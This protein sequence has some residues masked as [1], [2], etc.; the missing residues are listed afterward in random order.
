MH[1]VVAFVAVLTIGLTVVTQTWAENWARF[2]GP[3]GTGISPDKQVPVTFSDKEN[4]IWKTALPGL[5]NGSPIIWGNRLFVQSSSADA[6]TRMLL[7]LDTQDGKILWNTPVPG[8]SAK[9]HARNSLASSTPATD[10]QFVC[11]YF[12]DGQ[13]IAL[14][15]FDFQ[16]GKQL[17]KTPLG[18]YSSQHGAGHSPMLV[19]GKAVV[20]NDQDGTSEVVAVDAQTGK[21]AWKTPRKPFRACYSTPF[22]RENP[23]TGTELIIVSTAGVAGLDPKTGKENWRWDWTFDGMALRTVASAITGNGLV[24]VGSGDGSG[25]RHAVAIRPGTKGTIDDKNL[26]WEEK[27]SFPYVPAMLLRGD[28]LYWVNDRGFAA[29]YEAASGKEIWNERLGGDFSASPVLIDGKVYAIAMDGNAFVFE[30]APTYKLL[31]KNNMGE[32]VTASPAVSDNKLYIRG[33][34]HLFCI[35]KNVPAK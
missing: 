1:R 12:W 34:T 6:K 35:G 2:R 32:P 11:C 29:C 25:A 19:D 16:T 28:H 20:L 17:W 22:L 9:T 30:A 3:N 23:A 4:V 24:F 21:V 7:C 18:P 33:K 14:Y 15:G 5:G 26:V 8:G 27:K 13:D 10:G 31:A